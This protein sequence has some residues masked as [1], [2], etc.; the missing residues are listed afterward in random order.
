MDRLQ[1]TYTEVSQLAVDF[2]QYLGTL[3]NPISADMLTQTTRFVSSSIGPEKILAALSN[4][5][6]KSIAYPVIVLCVY[7]GLREQIHT[8]MSAITVKSVAHA[9]VITV[10]AA[11]KALDYVLFPFYNPRIDP[12]E[13]IL[14]K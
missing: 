6:P 4:M 2:Y 3:E 12:H 10:E 9:G 1:A 11:A 8:C 5:D 13:Y 7:A 14:C